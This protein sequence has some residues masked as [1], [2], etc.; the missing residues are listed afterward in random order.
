MKTQ[1]LLSAPEAQLVNQLKHMKIKELERHAQKILRNH[2]H[3]DYNDLMRTVIQTIPTLNPADSN[4]FELIQGLIN[5]RINAGISDANTENGVIQRLTVIFM[6]II[7][8]KF[9]KI[10]SGQSDTPLH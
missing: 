9:Q 6:V 2:G 5:S 4:R 10:H 8:K 7:T 3:T 1:E